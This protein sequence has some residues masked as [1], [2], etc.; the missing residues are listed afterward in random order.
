MIETI[1]AIVVGSCIVI[2]VAALRAFVEILIEDPVLEN[3]L[4]CIIVTALIL[5]GAFLL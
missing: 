2:L 1:A 5:L 3:I 4:D